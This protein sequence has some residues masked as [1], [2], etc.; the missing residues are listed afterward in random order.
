MPELRVRRDDLATCELA[1]GEPA[2]DEVADGEAQLRIERFALTTNNVTYGVLGDQLGYW[3][4]FPA[5]DGWGRIP[6]WGYATVTVSAAPGVAEGARVFGFVPMASHVTVR[7]VP[8]PLGFRDA[9][10]HSADLNPI[11]IQYL[12]VDDDAEDVALVWRPLF[13]TSVLLDLDLGENGLPG[14][15]VLTSASSKT[16]IGLAHLL[17]ERPVRVLGM[18]SPQRRSWVEGLGLYDDVLGYDELDALSAGDDVVLIDFT[19]DWALA[20]RLHERLGPSLR[21]S[22]LV[23]YTHR[24]GDAVEPPEAAVRFSTPAEIVRRGRTLATGYADAWSGFGPVAGR[25]LRIERITTGAALMAAYRDLL[26]GRADPG[27]A[28]IVELS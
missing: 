17:R 18:T 12:A 26:A 20:R 6:A 2:R 25:L 1:D 23:G 11:Y 3:R 21:R 10:P 19:G 24:R 9:S 5:P 16:A 14:A 22:L 4:R 27:V 28:N 8:H 15:A 13:G 7:P